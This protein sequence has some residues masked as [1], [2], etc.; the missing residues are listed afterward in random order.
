M[1]ALLTPN[2]NELAGTEAL[3]KSYRLT[4]PSDRKITNVKS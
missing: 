1:S 2:G 3:P 4:D